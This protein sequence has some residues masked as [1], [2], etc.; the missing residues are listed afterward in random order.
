M[1]APLRII[2][3]PSPRRLDTHKGDCGKIAIIA[4]S[5]GMSGAAILSGL[6]ALRGGA[7][8]VRVFTSAGAQPIIA[9][10]EP[11]LMTYALAE[12]RNGQISE[13]D[14]PDE[15]G[16]ADAVVI[17]P[18]LGRSGALDRLISDVYRTYRVPLVVDADALNSLAAGDQEIWN[19]RRDLPT[20]ITPHPGEMLRIVNGLPDVPEFLM[21]HEDERLPAAQNV[22]ARTGAIVVLKGHAT[23]VADG[24]RHY[25]NHTGNPGMAAGGMGDVLTGLIA[26]LIG[27]GLSPFDAAIRGVWLHGAAADRLARRIGPYGFLA[28]EVADEIP[29]VVRDETVEG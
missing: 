8:L 10:A 29:A 22:A 18:G 23:I 1:T 15:V 17:G 3:K 14:L 2:P 19:A 4:G 6:G 11:C 20:V 24:Q 26:A 25:E 28:R 5:R 16:R 13:N 9:A 27:Q 12:D 21:H 7:G